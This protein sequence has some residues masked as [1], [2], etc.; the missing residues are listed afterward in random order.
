MRAEWSE[1]GDDEDF[2]R[3][4]DRSKGVRHVE[5]VTGRAG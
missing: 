3:E 4:R 1:T 5:R 2:A